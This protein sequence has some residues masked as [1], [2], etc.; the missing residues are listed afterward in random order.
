MDFI[1]NENMGAPTLNEITLNLG[2]A[3]ILFERVVHNLE[4]MLAHQRVHGDFSAFNILYWNGDISMID[5]PQS[6]N[7]NK[8]PNSF[9]I[10]QRD[11]LRICEYF[12][13]QGVKTYSSELA[14]KLWAVNN[15]STTPNY[16]WPDEEDSN[17]EEKEQ[18]IP[19][20]IIRPEHKSD[21]ESI[22]KVNDLAFNRHEEGRLI[23]NLRQLPKFDPRLSL[24]AEKKGKIVG[25]ALFFP[26]TIQTENDEEYPCL[27]LGPIAVIPEHQNQGIGGL[28]IEEGHRAAMALNYTSVVLLGHPNY[29]PRFGYLPARQRHLTNPWNIIDDPWMAIELVEGS[30]AGKAGSVI[31]P[32]AFNEAT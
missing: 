2:E 30:L 9:A 29:Y 32:K 19:E 13:A 11:V 12:E 17:F 18:M 28:L 21:Y 22:K 24:V 14:E 5:F 23:D 15:Y 20:I 1:G 6:I 7:P 25:H 10:F 16:L 26:V 8:N 31:Y 27:S 3:R 4:L